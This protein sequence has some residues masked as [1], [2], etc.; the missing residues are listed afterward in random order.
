M[1][2][3]E[4]KQTKST[5][6]PHLLELR[7]RLSKILLFVLIIFIMLI[8]FSGEIY[9]TPLEELITVSPV[10]IIAGHHSTAIDF[11]MDDFSYFGITGSDYEIIIDASN[12]KIEQYRNTHYHR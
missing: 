6:L 12:E 10:N 7:N 9:V 4:T 3:Q 11:E 5:L 2:Q 8:P 1:K